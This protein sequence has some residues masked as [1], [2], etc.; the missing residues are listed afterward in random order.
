MIK[1]RLVALAA[2]IPADLKKRVQEYCDRRGVKLQFVIEEALDKKL[3]EEAEDRRDEKIALERL[4]NAEYVSE[5]QMNRYL[6]KRG[7]KS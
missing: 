2:K 3:R 5:E 7:I 4:K 6:R 1:P